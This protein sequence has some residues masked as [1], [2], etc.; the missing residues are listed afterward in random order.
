LI[1]TIGFSG[2]NYTYDHPVLIAQV[3]FLFVVSGMSLLGIAASA[4]R[5]EWLR[6]RRVLQVLLVSPALAFPLNDLFPVLAGS[7]AHGFLVAN[8][9]ISAV[10]GAAIALAIATAWLKPFHGGVGYEQY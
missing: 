6:A 3:V 9:F 1:L 8:F 4:F 5:P 10:V 2:R 7:E